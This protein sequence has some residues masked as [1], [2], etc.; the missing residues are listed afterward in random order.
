MSKPTSFG[1][2]VPL[3]PILRTAERT[4]TAHWGISYQKGELFLIRLELYIDLRADVWWPLQDFLDQFR[5]TAD[6]SNIGLGTGL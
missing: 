5:K 1:L 6:G 2:N 3:S 4:L